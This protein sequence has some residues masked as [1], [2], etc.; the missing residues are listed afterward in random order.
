[1]RIVVGENEKHILMFIPVISRGYL[2]NK[3]RDAID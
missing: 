3:L 1:M 2:Y